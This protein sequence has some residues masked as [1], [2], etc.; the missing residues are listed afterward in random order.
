MPESKPAP[1]LSARETERFWRNVDVRGPEECWPWNGYRTSH[2]GYGQLYA[3]GRTLRAHRIA[4][5][6]KHGDPHPLFACHRCDN[7]LCCNPAHLFAGTNADN[8][9]DRHAKGRDARELRHGLAKLSCEQVLEIR[10]LSAH[11]LNSFEIGP[12]FGV[13]PCT[14]RDIVSGR[15]RAA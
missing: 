14:V 7:R 11:G 3:A 8:T 6:L 9:S 4:Y 13:K 12:L 1:S 2:G 10:R 15:R 5:L